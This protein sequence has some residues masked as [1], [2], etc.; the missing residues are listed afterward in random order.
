[1]YLNEP[2]LHTISCDISYNSVMRQ[3]G[4]YPPTP[5]PEE[6][7]P[8]ASNNLGSWPSQVFSTG[9]NTFFTADDELNGRVIWALPRN[10]DA[11]L[12]A[13]VHPG[14]QSTHFTWL[15]TLNRKLIFLTKEA[16]VEFRLWRL[17]TDQVHELAQIGFSERNNDS[18]TERSNSRST[19]KP[20]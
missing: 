2:A 5:S 16:D 6:Q 15:S 13:D 8:I 18:T 11:T 19:C 3:R 1:M 9:K 7:G 17:D 12:I 14:P 4:K 10:S 20:H